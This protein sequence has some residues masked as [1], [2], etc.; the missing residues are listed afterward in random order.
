MQAAAQ[1][2]ENYKALYFARIFTEV[3]PQNAVGWQN[4]S[5]LASNLGLPEEALASQARASDPKSAQVVPAGFLPGRKVPVKPATLP[6]WAAALALLSQDLAATRGPAEELA[7]RD[8][9]SGVKVATADEVREN[10]AQL[11]KLNLPPEGPWADPKPLNVNQVLTN[12]FALKDAEAM[13]YHSVDGGKMF[14]AMMMAG[15]AGYSS[16]AA[17]AAA[18]LDSQVAGKLVTDASNVKSN[19]SGG[20]YAKLLYDKDSINGVTTSDK[21]KTSGKTHALGSPFP[22]LWGSGDPTAPT[23]LAALS[24]GQKP[25]VVEIKAGQEVPPG[26]EKVKLESLPPLHYPKFGIL[27]SA[28]CSYPV[29]LGEIILT[30]E[31]LQEFAPNL[32]SLLPDLTSLRT[33]YLSDGLTMSPG[34]YSA[35]TFIGFDERGDAFRF[36]VSPSVWIVPSRK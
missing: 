10:D 29:A 9:I 23:F 15:L 20:H 2:N 6:D 32:L 17:P 4:R 8:D 22:L 18:A 26:K 27:C 14:G 28:Q 36:S 34:N 3:E 21:P 1:A 12:C 19:Y 13:H 33:A 24:A 25:A 11:T 16:A 5:K 7:V 31:D 35:N 30:R